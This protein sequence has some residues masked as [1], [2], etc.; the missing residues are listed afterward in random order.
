MRGRFRKRPDSAECREQ[1]SM[2]TNMQQTRKE[3]LGVLGIETASSERGG[4]LKN[5]PLETCIKRNRFGV[6]FEEGSW[7][8]VHTPV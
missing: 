8:S 5:A 1:Q 2:R 4:N 3:K 6:A 7:N